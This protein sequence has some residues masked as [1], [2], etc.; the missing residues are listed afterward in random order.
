MQGFAKPVAVAFALACAWGVFAPSAGAQWVV[1]NKDG[2]TSLKLGFLAQPQAEGL[3]TPDG[4]QYSK[5]LFFRRFRIIMSGKVAEKWE[6][7]FETDSPNLGKADPSKATNPTGAKDQGSIYIQDAF[8]TYTQSPAFKVDAGLLLLPLSHNHE[9]SAATLLPVDYGLYSFVESTA[10]GERVGRDYG[11]EVRGY[12]AQQHL[13]YRLG[14]FS[15]FRGVE[16]TNQPRFTGRVAFYPWA[17]ETGYFYGGTFLG[18][19]QLLSIG[20]S[21]DTQKSYKSFGADAFYEQ[22]INGGDKAVTLQFDWTR[23]DGGS[24]VTALPKQDTYLVEAAFHFLKCQV[25]PFVQYS[26]RNFSAAATADQN[27]LQAGIAWWMKGHSRNLK[28]SAGRQHI[29]GE[30]DRVQVLAQLQIFYN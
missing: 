4:S 17:A 28:V 21:F 20:A 10:L 5:N 26:I 3:Q 2:T 13:E 15:G 14:I 1:E 18:T 24:F 7:F 6:Y 12:P 25:A 22:P 16:A 11:V 29:D 27:S 23:I 8:V 9:Q 30:K 19:K